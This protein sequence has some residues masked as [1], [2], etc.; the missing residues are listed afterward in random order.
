MCSNKTVT[1]LSKMRS[2]VRVGLAIQLPP[3]TYGLIIGR[4]SVAIDHRLDIMTGKK[5][6]MHPKIEIG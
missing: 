4:S 6:Q 3:H 5:N 1:L 2:L